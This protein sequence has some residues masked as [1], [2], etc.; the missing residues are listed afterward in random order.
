MDWAP[1]ILVAIVGVI[2]IIGLVVDR[3]QTSKS[4]SMSTTS[5]GNGRRNVTPELMGARFCSVCG[6]IWKSTYGMMI[7][8]GMLNNFA[9]FSG[10]FNT[11]SLAGLTCTSCQ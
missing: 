6:T 8:S 7:D 2:F 10:S 4:R 5:L 11:D 9:S 1:I 3:T